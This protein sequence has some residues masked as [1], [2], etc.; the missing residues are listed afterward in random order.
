MTKWAQDIADAQD[1]QGIVPPVVLKPPAAFLED[2]GPAW[3]DAAIYLSVD[4][5]PLLRG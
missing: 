5:L 4:D 3:S 2:G 1:E